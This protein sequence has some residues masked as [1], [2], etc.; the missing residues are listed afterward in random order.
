MGGEEYRGV[1]VAWEGRGAEGRRCREKIEMR[2]GWR[3]PGEGRRGGICLGF[4]EY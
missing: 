2:R 3:G 4:W 1:G